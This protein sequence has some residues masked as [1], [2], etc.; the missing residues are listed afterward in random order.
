MEAKTPLELYNGS[1]KDVPYLSKENPPALDYITFSYLN[2]V[3]DAG[4][5]KPFNFDMLNKVRKEHTYEYNYPLFKELV[6]KE[7]KEKPGTEYHTIFIKYLSRYGFVKGE[8][9][10]AASYLIQIP[11]PYLIKLLLEW[12]EDEDAP[13]W[14]GWSI[15]LII[16]MLSFFKPALMHY[17]TSIKVRLSVMGEICTRVSLQILGFLMTF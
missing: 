15:V 9:I 1:R 17:G 3:V 7:L 4:N 16:A 10:Q 11:I 13:G 2:K 6:E 12:I 14:H 5:R 8:W